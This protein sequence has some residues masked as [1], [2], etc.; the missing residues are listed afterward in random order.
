MY[1]QSSYR[2]CR[3]WTLELVRKV[4]G[5]AIPEV[6]NRNGMFYQACWLIHVP[7]AVSESALWVGCDYLVLGLKRRK[8]HQPANQSNKRS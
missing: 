6:Q 2:R 3:L 8:K 4:D 5:Q 1:S 7:I